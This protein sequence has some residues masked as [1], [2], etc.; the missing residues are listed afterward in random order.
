MTELERL[1][2]ENAE[3]QIKYDTSIIILQGRNKY[4]KIVE[5]KLAAAEADA[6]TLWHLAR[7]PIDVAE[8]KD[9]QAAEGVIKRLV[10]IDAAKTEV[11]K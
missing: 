8:C 5:D 11:R 7:C 6:K 2:R 10:A 4:V 3:L 1:Q 9:C